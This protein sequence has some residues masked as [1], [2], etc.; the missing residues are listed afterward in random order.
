M[1]V[2]DASG[3][4]LGNVDAIAPSELLVDDCFLTAF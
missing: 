4:A 2:G 3:L 1:I